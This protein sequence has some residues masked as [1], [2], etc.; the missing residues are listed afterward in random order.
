[1]FTFARN[2]VSGFCVEH[3]KQSFLRPRLERSTSHWGHQQ[4]VTMKRT[5]P[6]TRRDS[7]RRRWTTTGCSGTATSKKCQPQQPKM[8]L[9]RSS[10]SDSRQSVL[11]SALTVRMMLMTTVMTHTAVIVIFA[12]KIVPNLMIMTPYQTRT[13]TATVTMIVV[14]T[15]SD[16]CRGRRN[17]QHSRP[18]KSW[19]CL[20]S[21][22]Q[23]ALPKVLLQLGSRR[24]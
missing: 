12:M 15:V 22:C 13:A 14:H 4:R 3:S 11:L 16:Q 21:S 18:S 20:Y 9:Q 10:V 23:R 1:M 2:C 7:T 17:A 24:F 19:C 8:R 6:H 5:L